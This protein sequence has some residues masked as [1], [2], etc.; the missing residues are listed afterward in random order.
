VCTCVKKT[1]EVNETVDDACSLPKESGLCKGSFQRF[2]YDNETQECKQFTYGGCS[3]NGNNFHTIEF[4][5][6]RCMKRNH[7]NL[8]YENNT[9][10][11]VAKCFMKKESGICMAYFKKYFY[12][13]ETNQCEEFVYGN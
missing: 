2:Y 10:Q 3:G 12:N 13:S 7:T 5:Q 1:V 8:A 9:N 11:S 6:R 4:C